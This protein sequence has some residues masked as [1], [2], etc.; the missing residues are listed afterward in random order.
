MAVSERETVTFSCKL[1]ELF[2]FLNEI[3]TIVT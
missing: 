3:P 2:F 1:N